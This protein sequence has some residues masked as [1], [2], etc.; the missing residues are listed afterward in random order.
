VS[1]GG[2]GTGAGHNPLVQPRSPAWAYGRAFGHRAQHVVDRT[3]DVNTAEG[4]IN[5]WVQFHQ[6]QCSGVD[7][8]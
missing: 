1:E 2:N 7:C 4:Q 6:C 3:C 5:N 8:A